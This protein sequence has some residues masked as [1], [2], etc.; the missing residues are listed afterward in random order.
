MIPLGFI[1][2]VQGLECILNKTYNKSIYMGT[3]L[4]TL[5][6]SE[7]QELLQK[8][9]ATNYQLIE[10]SENIGKEYESLLEKSNNLCKNYFELY[11]KQKEEIKEMERVISQLKMELS[12]K[13]WKRI[14]NHKKLEL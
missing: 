12:K 4:I 9:N 3:K 7:Y 5:P 11:T 13:W 6:Y 10:E 1:T 2:A 8:A 14:F